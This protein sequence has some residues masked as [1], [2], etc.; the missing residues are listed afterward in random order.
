L[1]K[2]RDPLVNFRLRGW[3]IVTHIINPCRIHGIGKMQERR[4]G[5]IAVDLVDPTMPS[6]FQQRGA[7]QKLS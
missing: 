1:A 7:I 4:S 3:H 6:R 2:A 5:V